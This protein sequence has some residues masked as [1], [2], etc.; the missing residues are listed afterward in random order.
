MRAILTTITA[1]LLLLTPTAALP[2]AVAPASP[3]PA[4]TPQC[5]AP[6]YPDTAALLAAL[7]GAPYACAE[8]LAAALRPR[9]DLATTDALITLAATGPHALAR[10]NALRALG[11]LAES[12]RGSRARELV[13]Q[14]RAARL[15]A[16]LSGLLAGEQDNF[17]VQDAVWL[18]DSF[19]YPSFHDGPALTR[20]A[21]DPALAPALRYRAAAAR[22]RLIYARPGPL[23]SDDRAFIHGGLQSDSPGVRAAAALAVAHLRNAQLDTRLRAELDT[24][25]A[26]AWAA[27]PALQLAPDQPPP[28]MGFAESSPTSLTARAAIARARDRLAGGTTHLARLRIDYEALALPNRLSA[29][30]V[31]LRSG[32]PV[33]Q[34]TP[35]LAEIT[36][37]QATFNAIVGP[38]LSGPIPGEDGP[39]LSVFIFARQGIYRDYLRAFTSFTVDVDGVY[40]ELTATLYTHART[41]EQSANSLEQ[42]LRHELA[43]H[44]AGRQIFP[45]HWQSPGYHAEPKGW[46]DEGLAELLAGAGPAGPAP[47]P[48]QLGRLCALRA[49][50]ALGELLARRAGY[51]HFGHFDY[52]AAWAL[53]Y[54]LYRERPAALRRLYAAFRDGSYRLAGWPRIVGA[55][56]ATLEAEWHAAISGWCEGHVN[57]VRPAIEAAG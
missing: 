8:E 50:P 51:D 4:R 6:G 36:H 38:E 12:P 2:L 27:E 29:N 25:L 7:P 28:V 20:L 32:L 40:D 21:A 14:A 31:T 33:A 55:P 11:R 19:F 26:A 18:V 46:A 9:A 3:P 41:A 23:A 42:T 49:P 10:R 48:A 53:S 56:L 15:R 17:L 5:P 24:A 22:A 37:T 45:G 16:T 34:L 52:D 30:G 57:V 39:A 47:R 1:A 35:L 44:L 13:L 54:Y 43:H